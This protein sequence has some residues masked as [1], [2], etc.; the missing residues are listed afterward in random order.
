MSIL[1]ASILVLICW[2]FM[3]D[4]IPALNP[5]GLER[6]WEREDWSWGRFGGYWNTDNRYSVTFEPIQQISRYQRG[7]GIFFVA[8]MRRVDHYSFIGRQLKRPCQVKIDA[9]FYRNA[10]VERLYSWGKV[11]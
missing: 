9:V 11:E 2:Y 3:W 7:I 8:T 1:L 4:F 10:V 6:I 5:E